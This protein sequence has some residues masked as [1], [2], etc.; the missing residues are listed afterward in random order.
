MIIFGN[1]A[2]GLE[3][4]PQSKTNE[5]LLYL[6]E[7]VQTGPTTCGVITETPS[8]PRHERFEP[9]QSLTSLLRVRMLINNIYLLCEEVLP[10]ESHCSLLLLQRKRSL[11]QTSYVE[12][13]LV[14]DN[15]RVSVLLIDPHES[16]HVHIIIWLQEVCVCR[17]GAIYEHH[18]LLELH[19]LLY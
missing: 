8:V 2:F 10:F 18:L 3:P 4:V 7:D 1:E 16:T 6:L 11:A 19:C 5:H 13:A 14:V 9:G 12:L 15:L 17:L